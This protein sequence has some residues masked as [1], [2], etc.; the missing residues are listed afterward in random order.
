MPL[1][2]SQPDRPAGRRRRPTAPPV[3]DV[4]H[5]LGL[6]CLQPERVVDALPELRALQPDVGVVCA[7]G[8]ILPADVLGLCPW[9]NLHPSILPRWRGAAPIERALM[10][11]DTETAVTVMQTVE[12][13]DAGPVVAMTRFPIGSDDDAGDVAEAALRLG[14]PLLITAIGAA[15]DGV[16]TSTPQSDDGVTYAAKVTRED[17]LLDPA[18]CTVHGAHDRVRAL[19]PGIGALLDL[20]DGP[21]TVWRTSPDGAAIAPG[22]VEVSGDDLVVGFADGALRILELQSPG[23]RALPAADWLRGL[24]SAPTCARRPA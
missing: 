11:G 3:A 17:R 13:L 19:R 18:V 23:R 6:T 24:R 2:V 14:V 4:A 12:A 1:V 5:D 20:G 15:G 7:Y 10:A 16:P 8:Q 21:V 22:A 9:L